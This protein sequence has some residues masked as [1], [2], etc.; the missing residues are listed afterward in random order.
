MLLEVKT[1][2]LY[3]ASVREAEL[4]LTTQWGMLGYRL[5]ILTEEEAEKA[6]EA[7]HLAQ[8]AHE[9]ALR[10]PAEFER[11][12]KAFQ[13]KRLIAMDQFRAWL[14]EQPTTFDLKKI[15]EEAQP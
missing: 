3:A 12:L 15:L 6:L 8:A 10:D 9:A 7:F 11:R 4:V 13:L 5:P 14:A 2:K 1:R